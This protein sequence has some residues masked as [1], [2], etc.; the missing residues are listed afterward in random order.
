MFET[1][2]HRWIWSAAGFFHLA[3]LAC[4]VAAG[5]TASRPEKANDGGLM[6]VVLEDEAIVQPGEVPEGIATGKGA[7]VAQ[8]VDFTAVT[9]KTLPVIAQPSAAAVV[10]APA[11]VA[12]STKVESR[13]V[14]PAEF[15][16]PA[17]LIRKEPV[18]PERT[19]RAGIEGRVV[20]K[21]LISA[22]GAIRA[23]EVVVSSGNQALDQSALQAVRASKFSPARSDHSPV[24]SHATASYRFE[25]R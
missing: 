22:T 23:T 21:I 14:T 6:L 15:V 19:R 5:S 13:G 8:P 12:T 18:Y 24:E 20:L 7:M 3:A 2:R 17:F 1:P 11:A 25:L 16:P 4:V 10:A 9:T